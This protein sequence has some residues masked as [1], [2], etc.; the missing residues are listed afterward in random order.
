MLVLTRKVG[1]QIVINE[2]IRITLVAIRGDRARLGIAAPRETVVDRREIHERRS[3]QRDGFN[4][5]SSG[6]EAM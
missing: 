4:P 2:D 1:E 5:Q 6:D 3:A